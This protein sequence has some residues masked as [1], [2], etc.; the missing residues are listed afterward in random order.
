MTSVR[1]SDNITEIGD[2][3]FTRCY[4]LKDINIPKNNLQRIGDYAF[5]GCSNIEELTLPST[6]MEIV[7][8]AFVGCQGLR[9]VTVDEGNPKFLAEDGVLFNHDKTTLMLFP[10]Q[11]D[12][13]HYDIPTTVTTIVPAAFLGSKLKSITLPPALTEI[14]RSALCGLAQLESIIIPPSVTAIEFAAFSGCASLK[15][16]DVP[17]GVKSIG[18][19]A[20]VDCSSLVRVHLPEGLARIEGWTFDGCTSLSEVNVPEGVNY[21]GMAAFRNCSSL[22]TFQIPQGVTTIDDVAFQNC[23]TPVELIIPDMVTTVG[24]DAFMG[25]SGLEKITI[26]HSV[27]K[28]EG[29]TF[30]GCD[31]IRD[32]R[33]YIEEPF[34][35]NDYES[36]D[37]VI[38]IGKCFPDEVTS[39]AILYVPQGTIEKYRSK[40]GWRDFVDISDTI[41]T[42]VAEMS[43]PSEINSP[44]YN[45][46]GQRLNGTPTKG[47][48]IQ[49]GKKK[50][51]KL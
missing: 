12:K 37:G 27:T 13:T 34:D 25:C 20:F 24:G 18:S 38:L 49:N 35:V 10:A 1:L 48:Y 9:S 7:E 15:E 43:A 6:L 4:K 32:V 36:N 22:P 46:S 42:G 51:I 17:N 23:S 47:I 33:S 5:L 21:I 39:N 29:G 40:R 19:S 41:E 45:L 50:L 28:L 8:S 11:S 26:G 30:Y 44:Y 16:V 3:T 31:N 2:W 14:G